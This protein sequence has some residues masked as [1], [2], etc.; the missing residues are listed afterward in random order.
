MFNTTSR[1]SLTLS[2]EILT[3]RGGSSKSDDSNKFLNFYPKLSLSRRCVNFTSIKLENKKYL[4][5]IR[6]TTQR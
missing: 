2:F 1:T 6:G 5:G 3:G 4:L